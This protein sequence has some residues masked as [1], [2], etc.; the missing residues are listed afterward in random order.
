MRTNLELS[1]SIEDQTGNHIE[2]NDGEEDPE[3]S[4]DN[5]THPEIIERLTSFPAEVKHVKIISNIV[6][7]HYNSRCEIM[8]IDAK[9]E[10]T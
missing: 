9:E 5:E 3:A 10:Y 4:I 1:E 2:S 7:F 8:I 6:A